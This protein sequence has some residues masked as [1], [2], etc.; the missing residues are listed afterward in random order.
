MFIT[1]IWRPNQFAHQLGTNQMAPLPGMMP[2]H[3]DMIFSKHLWSSSQVRWLFF[4]FTNVLYLF[5][6]N[7]SCFNLPFDM[8]L[9]NLN[10]FV[11]LFSFYFF[12]FPYFSCFSCLFFVLFQLLLVMYAILDTRQWGKTCGNWK[13][14]WDGVGVVLDY[15]GGYIWRSA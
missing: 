11:D 2:L 12:C 13:S 3:S 1:P 7:C 5:S 8:F 9:V 14:S 4:S 6:F 15:H 10:L